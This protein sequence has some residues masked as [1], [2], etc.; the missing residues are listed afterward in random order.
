MA[1]D[2]DVYYQHK[3]LDR[4]HSLITGT[5]QYDLIKGATIYILLCPL[6]I[7]MLTTIDWTHE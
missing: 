7:H 4:S 2:Y 3:P 6:V 1:M 5:L